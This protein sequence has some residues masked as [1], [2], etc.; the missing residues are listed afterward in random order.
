[1]CLMKINLV[2]L[3]RCAALCA[4]HVHESFFLL[5]FPFLFFPIDAQQPPHHVR[6]AR[7]FVFR[8]KQPGELR[9]FTLESKSI[10]SVVSERWL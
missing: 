4:S 3:G 10:A 9:I 1:L 8:H 2:L 5:L 6:F 7:A